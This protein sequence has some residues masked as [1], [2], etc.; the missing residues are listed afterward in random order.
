MTKITL[1]DLV[2]LQNETS[3][4]NTLN[5][6]S[7]VIETA[8][9][10]TLSRDG[11]SP[12]QMA[13]ALDM[14]GNRIINLP[15]PMTD[16]E[17]VRKGEFDQAA[18]GGTYT[19]NIPIASSNTFTGNNVFTQPLAI[20]NMSTGLGVS[21]GDAAF[22]VGLYRTG[23]GAAFI[24]LHSTAGGDFDSRILKSG[25]PNSDFSL[26]NT[27][28]GNI[29]LTQGTTIYKFDSTGFTNFVDRGFNLQ[30]QTSAA[31]AS[32]ATLT[33]SP[34]AGNPNFWL[35]IKINSVNYSIPCWVG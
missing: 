31:G 12:N 19:G 18:F 16:S 4:V 21:T 6:N 10:N 22:E 26:I 15:S 20:A 25:G 8:F 9:D 24:D 17:P 32:T 34:T 7:A 27:G 14:N 11:T 2:N 35:K 33:N 23:V 30:S 28:S 1:D 5:S 3:A 13:A 29:N